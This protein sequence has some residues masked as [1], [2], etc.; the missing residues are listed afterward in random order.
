MLEV[1]LLYKK[2]ENYN[3]VLEQTVQERTGE[4]LR[5]NEQL[6]QEIEERKGTEESLQSAYAENKQ[7]KDR[8]QAENIYL[9]QEVDREYNF[10]EIIGQSNAIS[11][12][13][14]SRSSRWRPRMRPFFSLARPAPA[15]EWWR[16]PSTAGAPAR[17]GR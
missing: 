7:L 16:A 14:S 11:S 8:L 1:R 9:Q 15:R 17:T 12:M 13:C 5:A 2:I 6:S 3:K 4:L 10:G